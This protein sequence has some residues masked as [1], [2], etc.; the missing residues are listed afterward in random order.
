[1]RITFELKQCRKGGEKMEYFKKLVGDRNKHTIKAVVS[2][3]IPSDVTHEISKT[4]K[5][6]NLLVAQLRQKQ[7]KYKP[8]K[9]NNVIYHRYYELYKDKNSKIYN[10]LLGPNSTRIKHYEEA[11]AENPVDISLIKSDINL[12]N[13]LNNNS[14]LVVNKTNNNS[15]FYGG[16]NNN[17]NKSINYNIRNV[18]RDFNK[19]MSSF[20]GNKRRSLSDNKYFNS[21]LV[22]SSFGYSSALIYPPN[23]CLGKLGYY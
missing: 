16:F 9:D 6:F 21:K 4:Q 10:S 19:N 1:M 7:S 5:Q 11:E 22:G 12:K 15:T 13:S 8:I 20:N 17:A 2:L 14:N 18:S 23:K 3:N